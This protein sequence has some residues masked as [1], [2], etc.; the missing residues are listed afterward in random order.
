M[1]APLDEGIRK[2]AT[3]LV[4]GLSAHVETYG[5]AAGC[6]SS[7]GI[8]APGGKLFRSHAL[9]DSLRA[10]GPDL[11]VYVPSASGTLFSFLRARSLKRI[12]PSAHVALVLT[13][14]RRHTA[15]VRMLLHRLAPDS[16]FCQSAAT[17]RYLE[18]IGIASRFLPSGVDLAAFQPVSPAE[19]DRLRVKYR[20]PAGE[21][22]VLHAGHLTR[23]RNTGL[24][25][26]LEG[27]GRGVM[28]AGRSAGRDPQ[29]KRRLEEQGVIVIDTYVERVEE[30]YQAVDCYLFPVRQEDAAMEFPL[31]VL[32]AMA[33][34]LP[35]VAHPYGGLPLALEP[36]DGLVFAESDDEML[37]AVRKSKHIHANTRDQ[38]KS[39]GWASVAARV[40]DAA[41]V[42]NAGAIVAAV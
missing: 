3:C 28:L 7:A 24:L 34:N 17:M 5:I 9:R 39:F 42:R 2:F 38:A 16:V 31:S 29:I 40:L 14:G 12:Q 21:F 30:L 11:I 22:L 32:E 15:P 4:G 26:K 37:D 36:R 1:G 19:K 41:E 33:C 10:V 13:Q 20:L 27:V 35:V 8:R 18:S 6:G 23:E 25:G